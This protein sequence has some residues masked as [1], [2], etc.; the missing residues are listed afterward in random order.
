M[1]FPRHHLAISHYT[2]LQ[3]WKSLCLKFP[4]DAC[5]SPTNPPAPSESRVWIRDWQLVKNI[6]NTCCWSSTASAHC[7][8]FIVGR[9]YCKRSFVVFCW[10]HPGFCVLSRFHWPDCYPTGFKHS[11]ELLWTPEMLTG[12]TSESSLYADKIY[13]IL[14]LTIIDTR[15]VVRTPRSRPLCFFWVLNISEYIFVTHYDN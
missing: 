1:W 7:M 8:N 6:S 14:F 13:G 12:S 11:L 5:S 3:V 9:A 15:H 10:Y 2:T 4:T